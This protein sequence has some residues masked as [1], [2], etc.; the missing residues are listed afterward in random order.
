MLLMTKSNTSF[1]MWGATLLIE[2]FSPG[3]SLGKTTQLDMQHSFLFIQITSI[4]TAFFLDRSFLIFPLSFG[5]QCTPPHSKNL[6]TVTHILSFQTP[7]GMTLR[8]CDLAWWLSA[9]K[10]LLLLQV[11]FLVF[12]ELGMNYLNI[13]PLPSDFYFL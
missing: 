10:Q 5:K 3:H 7:C 9:K 2:W 6:P 12:L 11:F 8:R 1:M 4:F 13:F